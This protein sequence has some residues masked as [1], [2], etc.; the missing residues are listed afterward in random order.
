MFSNIADYIHEKRHPDDHREALGYSERLDRYN[1]V[2]IVFKDGQPHRPIPVQG[3][4][5]LHFDASAPTSDRRKQLRI[6]RDA[7]TTA[8]R[9]AARFADSAA[10]LWI[11]KDWL[12]D[13]TERSCVIDEL[14][15]RG[16]INRQQRNES[17]TVNH[18]T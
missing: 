11:P 4:G 7:A 12:Y 10:I 18:A 3:H 15:K 6:L 14:Y 13:R 17:R 16:F 9:R 2:A 8:D 5:I 1:I